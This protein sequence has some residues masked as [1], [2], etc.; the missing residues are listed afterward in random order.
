MQKK[1]HKDGSNRLYS[2]ACRTVQYDLSDAEAVAAIKQYAA[3][4]PFPKNW[5][6]DEI[7]TRIRDA[8]QKVERGTAP[9]PEDRKS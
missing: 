5:L 9:K 4:K 2:A 3:Q 1:D 7:L 6:D 8:E